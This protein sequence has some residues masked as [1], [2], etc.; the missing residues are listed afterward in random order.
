MTQAELI[1]TDTAASMRAIVSELSNLLIE[2]RP[3]VEAV[4]ITLLAGK[5]A[6]LLGPPGT[7]KSLLLRMFAERFIGCQYFQILLDK[8]LGKEEVFG[9]YDLPLYD[10]EGVFERDPEGFAPTAHIAFFDEV[11]KSGPATLNPLLQ[12]VNEH[13]YRRGRKLVKAPLISAFGAS[14]ELLEDELEAFWDRFLIRMFVDYIKEPTSFVA[15]IRSAVPEAPPRSFTTLK[16]E[17]LLF[18]VEQEVPEI[19]LPVS[20]EN[21][22]ATLWRQV[23]NEGM[24]VSDRRWRES[25]RLLQASAYLNGRDEVDADDFLI[26]R[27]VLW[28]KPEEVHKVTELV[29]NFASETVR[30]IIGIEKM[31]DDINQ[32]ME[33][34]LAL[35]ANDKG[36]EQLSKFRIDAKVKVGNAH[37]AVVTF[38][39]N[40]VEKNK[41]AVRLDQ[42]ASE[43]Q[44][45]DFRILHELMNLDATAASNAVSYSWSDYPE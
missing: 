4:A 8:Q 24:E 23:K 14:N 1:K 45:I 9:Q 32:E 37:Q 18:A 15:L 22:I 12:L 19:K 42:L 29:T 3:H 25:I 34:I 17:D 39:K 30:T 7:A 26:L 40:A 13:E 43:L 28:S 11:G 21:D 41:P 2:R 35:V 36:G 33:K 31:I 5:N 10:K 38:K 16:L 6:L 44:R 20:V 27:H